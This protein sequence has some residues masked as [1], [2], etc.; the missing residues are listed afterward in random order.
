M[1][2]SKG[3]MVVRLKKG[4]RNRDFWLSC[5]QTPEEP[6]HREC[7][8]TIN[9]SSFKRH[10]KGVVWNLESEPEATQAPREKKLPTDDRNNTQNHDGETFGF[11]DAIIKLKKFFTDYPSL[12]ELG[13][14]LKYAKGTE[15]IDVFYRHLISMK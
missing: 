7:R 1:K 3:A 5:H 8:S 11:M 6:P 13:R 15:R 10:P 14:Q 4:G 2:Q 12:L 9:I